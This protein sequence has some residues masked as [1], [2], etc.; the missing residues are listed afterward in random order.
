MVQ[1]ILDLLKIHSPA[2]Q[3]KEKK[4]K[5]YPLKILGH[6]DALVDVSEI[7]PNG[8]LRMF[9]AKTGGRYQYYVR[10]SEIL[11]HSDNRELVELVKDKYPEFCIGKD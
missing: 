5:K 7:T 1:C 3:F 2:I 11:S 6:D 8:R 10:V 9:H 4:E